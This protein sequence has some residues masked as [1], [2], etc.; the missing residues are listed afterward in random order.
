[1]WVWVP[2]I[3]FVVSFFDR[4]ALMPS[5]VLAAQ[6]CPPNLALEGTMYSVFS[7]VSDL[8]TL[9]S[10]AVGSRMSSHLHISYSDWSPTTLSSS[11]SP[12]PFPS[13]LSCSS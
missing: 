13:F 7:S 11:F 8:G 3:G 4:M 5:V 1:M 10:A 9:A 6:S 12:S 2:V